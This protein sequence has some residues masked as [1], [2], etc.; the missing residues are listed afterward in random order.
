M[1]KRKPIAE[2]YA[3]DVLSG[4]ILSCEYIKLACK[5]Y[6]NDRKTGVDRG[7]FFNRKK[8]EKA[9][10]FFSFLK[11]FKGEV[12]GKPFVLEPWQ[13]FFIWNVFGFENADKTR[14]FTQVLL[15]VAKKNGKSALAGGIAD[16]MLIADG[17]NG[18]EIYSAATTRDQAQEIFK[19]AKKMLEKSVLNRV[20]DIYENSVTFPETSS[21]IKP[22]SSDA[23][24][25]E[26]KN[27]SAGL[28]DEIHVHKNFELISNIKTAMVNRK[29][30]LL[31]MF[32][33]RGYNKKGPLMQI[34]KALINVLKGVFVQ[35][36][37]FGM[38]FTLDEADDWEKTENWIKAN[39]NLN[40]SVEQKKLEQQC[41]DAKNNPSMLVGFLTKNLNIWQEASAVWIKD[42]NWMKAQSE[43]DI[44]SL[45]GR[46]CFGALDLAS[47]SDINCFGLLFPPLT[48]DEQFIFLAFFFLPEE[49]VL[50]RVKNE[51]VMYDV[52]IRDGFIFPT[53]GNVTDYDFIY[54]LITGQ[55][56]SGDKAEKEGLAEMFNI[57]SIAYD[58]WNSSQLVIWLTENGFEMSQFR[59]G[60]ATMSPPTKELEKIVA[61][62]QLNHGENPVLR[63]MCGNVALQRDPAGNIKIDKN[64]SN[65]KVDGMVTLV[66]TIG[67]FMTNG[68]MI[69]AEPEFYFLKS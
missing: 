58:P 62:E 21:F 48:E 12:A 22:I 5:R 18:A 37:T 41:S 6:Y 4:K 14:R 52:W 65:E 68:D 23:N 61:K 50:E 54:A 59:Q 64:K 8:A 11:H 26:G 55:T 67:E 27:P 45:K 28:I 16:Y 25:F 24:S 34:E 66:M 46:D 60:Y 1:K 13:Q 35:D 29:N 15:C 9:I 20:C 36:H 43:I 49:T 31:A 2:Q 40:V 47:T 10:K 19:P 38:I 56:H 32:T 69:T 63:W 17:E 30:P 7:I 33:T 53:P 51:N 57:V 44:E 42:K 39:P 3:D